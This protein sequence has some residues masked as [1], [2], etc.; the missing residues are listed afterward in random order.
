MVINGGTIVE[1]DSESAKYFHFIAKFLALFFRFSSMVNECVSRQGEVRCIWHATVCQIVKL[2]WCFSKS[3]WKWDEI[4]VLSYLTKT[5]PEK[6]NSS[7]VLMWSICVN[8][9]CLASN[10]GVCTHSIPNIVLHMVVSH[11]TKRNGLLNRY[12]VSKM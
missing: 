8:C 3:F 4:P 1:V 10:L 11:A 5:C 7:E 9:R 2:C 6:L 12:S